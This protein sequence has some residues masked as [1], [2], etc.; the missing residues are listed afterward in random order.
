MVQAVDA[1]G[2]AGRD[3]EAA[4]EKSKSDQAKLESEIQQRGIVER[5]DTINAL[6]NHRWISLA[7][8]AFILAVILNNQTLIAMSAFM[9]VI[10]TAAW[11]WSRNSLVYISYQRRFYHTH[12]FPEEKTEVEIIVENKKRLP[13]TWLQAEDAWPRNFAPTTRTLLTERI[14]DS[15][16]GTLYNA[17]SLRWFERIRRHYEIQAIARGVY[18]IGPVEILSGD[19]FS[20]FERRLIKDERK[21]FLVIYPEVKPLPELGFPLLDPFGDRRVQRRL[22]E[23]PARVIG[24]R[25]YQ[26]HDSFRMV[27]WKAS[28][29]VSKLQTK[30]YEPT[31]GTNLVVALN[32]ATFEQHWRGVWPDMLEY[33]ITVAASIAKWAAEQNYGIGLISNGALS[34][35]D[36]SFRLLPSRSPNQL[37]HVL[38]ALAAIKYF[39][40]DEFGHFILSESP[41]LPLGATMVLVTPFISESIAISTLRLR[42][43]GRRLVWVVL[44]KKTPPNIHKMLYYHLPIGL[45]E[46]DLE[47]LE[48]LNADQSEEEINPRQKFLRQKARDQA[49]RE[50]SK[51]DLYG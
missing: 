36:Q 17:Y 24:V 25:D 32:I 15:S 3:A 23:D 26:P 9:L 16:Y 20:L 50:K 30:I 7:V 31:R 34:R 10:V 22:F 35:S 4:L 47:D 14:G 39:V 45:E 46:P 28:A 51:A 37:T 13:V 19:P 1:G 43:S 40:T 33:S 5:G 42:E 12:V 8:I 48:K 41:R 49:R 27:H 6:L 21:D 2:L 11:F 18:E 38:E 29:R 44:G